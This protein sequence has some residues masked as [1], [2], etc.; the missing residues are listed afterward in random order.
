MEKAC[1]TLCWSC[2]YL[3]SRVAQD[4]Q[5]NWVS[6]PACELSRFRIKGFPFLIATPHLNAVLS[7]KKICWDWKIVLKVTIKEASV[8]LKRIFEI[9]HKKS[10]L[11]K[12]MEKGGIQYFVV[13]QWENLSRLVN[14]FLMSC[15]NNH[16]IFICGHL[17]N[18]NY[19]VTSS[20]K[21]GSISGFHPIFSECKH[22]STR[23]KA[24]DFLFEGKR[25]SYSIVSYFLKFGM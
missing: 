14:F 4:V 12:T 5:R 8:Y 3:W 7:S 21:Q 16:S 2:H 24:Q 19:F 25:V 1:L 13:V 17:Q 11:I 22:L 6:T 9:P 10:C 20:C 15:K 23:L 18:I